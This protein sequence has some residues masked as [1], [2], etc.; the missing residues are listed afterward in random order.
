MSPKGLSQA[1]ITRLNR[2]LDQG[3][4]LIIATGRDFANT[5]KPLNGLKLTH[6]IILTNGA[7][8]ADLAREEY[9]QV[10]TLDKSISAEILELAY[11]HKINPIVFAVFKESMQEVIFKKGQWSKNEHRALDHAEYEA[12]LQDAVISIQ[13]CDQKAKIFPLYET[14]KENYANRINLIFIREVGLDEYY[15]LEINSPAA[16]K[17]KMLEYYLTSQGLSWTEV[18]AFGDQM[19]D[20]EMLRKAGQSFSPSDADP[21]L[22]EIVDEVLPSSMNNPVI[23]KIEEIW[24]S[25]RG[26]GP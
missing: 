19:N 23:A 14:I 22:Q 4:E 5:R 6:P 25:S 7:I 13:F 2:L 20:F 18:V 16:G 12:Y 3:L 8:L 11:H 17:E 24:A 21:R 26:T 9:H 15:W 10:F 1:E